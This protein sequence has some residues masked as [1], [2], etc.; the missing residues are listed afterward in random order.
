L[1]L[2]PQVEVHVHDSTADLRILVVPLRPPNTEG[3]TEAMLRPLATRDSMIG[4]AMAT[5]PPRQA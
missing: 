3:W 4:V 5:V 1:R 2:T